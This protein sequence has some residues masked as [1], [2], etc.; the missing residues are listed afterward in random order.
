MKKCLKP[1][2]IIISITFLALF[3][4]LLTCKK[5]DEPEKIKITCEAGCTS[6]SW[7]IVDESGPTST[8]ETCTLDWVGNNYIETCNG[9]ITYTTSGNTYNFSVIYDWIN[10]DITLTVTGLG[11]CTDTAGKKKSAD[12]DCDESAKKT[13]G[14]K[15]VVYKSMQEN[16]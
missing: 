11:T 3:F 5:E 13:G 12:C 10:C 16:N 9:T 8:T 6:M 7:E 4:I 1:K 15:I 14:T 2:S